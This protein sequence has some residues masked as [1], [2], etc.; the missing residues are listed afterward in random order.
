MFELTYDRKRKPFLTFTS[1]KVIGLILLGISQLT[2]AFYAFSYTIVIPVESIKDDTTAESIYN[3]IISVVSGNFNGEVD[4]IGAYKSLISNWPN[5]KNIFTLGKVVPI[6]LLIGLFSNLAQERKSI[7]R[8]II[9]YGIFTV[10]FYVG[11]LSFYYFFLIPTVDSIGES[12]LLDRVTIEVAEVGAVTAMSLFANFNIFIDLFM[13]SLFYFF[14]VYFP[15]KGFFKRHRKVFRSLVAIPVLY[16]I[17]S[18][19]FTYLAKTKITIPLDIMALFSSR[20]IYA[21]LF[22]YLITLYYKYRRKL[23]EKSNFQ[24]GL[25][26]KRYIKTSSSRLDFALIIGL[27]M[28]LTSL[29]E[30]IFYDLTMAKVFDFSLLS[31]GR[32]VHL[33]SFS[34]LLLFFDFTRRPRFKF[35]NVLYVVY[36]LILAV[37]LVGLYILVLDYALTVLKI[38]STVVEN[39]P[40]EA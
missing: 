15:K 13:C 5:I 30:K 33:Y 32:G 12:Y 26:F 34:F 20:G 24:Y 6:F 36:Y 22:F 1:F 31:L 38:A 7:I 8:I 39:L 21:H 18:M 40:I 10:L 37:I 28:L 14:V 9:K 2:L 3:L 17:A 35:F 29:Y 27:V 19:V 25:E 23:Y 11:E 16:I 4:T